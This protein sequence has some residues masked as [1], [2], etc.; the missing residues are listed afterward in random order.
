MDTKS[1]GL[2]IREHR[3]SLGYSESG[4][5][6]KVGISTRALQSYER[7]ERTPRDQVKIS[8]A[9]VLKVSVQEIFF[10]Q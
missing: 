7:G 8:M 4:F 3:I 10:D 9:R 2:K 1:I 6:T 5:S